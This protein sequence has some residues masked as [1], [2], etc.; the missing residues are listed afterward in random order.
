MSRNKDIKFLHDFTGLSYKECRQRMKRHHWDLVEALGLNTN[1]YDA[2]KAFCDSVADAA[3]LICKGIY[4]I[5]EE[6]A[7]AIS[8]VDWKTVAENLNKYKEIE[9]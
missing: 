6:M 4:K 5:G 2:L 8:S 3:G 1:L 9:T 7:A